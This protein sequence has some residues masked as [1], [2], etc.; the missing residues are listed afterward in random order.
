MK[1]AGPDRQARTFAQRGVLSFAAPQGE[2][3]A[4]KPETLPFQHASL[5]IDEENRR[6]SQPNAGQNRVIQALAHLPGS[7][8]AFVSVDI[9]RHGLDPSRLPILTPVI[10]SPP[11]NVVLEGNRRLAALKVL[12]NPELVSD[13]VKSKCSKPIRRLSRQCQG[14]PIEIV[15]SLSLRT[16]RKLGIGSIA[17]HGANEG[18]GVIPW[19]SDEAA[20]FRARS[21]TPEPHS[22]ALDFL[23]RRG[24]LTP[25]LR[26]RVPA[27]TF[28]R[29]IE[30]PEVRGKLGVE[31]QKGA[32]RLLADERQIAKPLM[33]AVNDLA[34][35]N[36]KIGNVYTKQQ[37]QKY[38]RDFPAHFAV[39]ATDK[40]R[41]RDRRLLCRIR[42]E[43][44]Y[45]AASPWLPS[46]FGRIFRLLEIGRDMQSASIALSAL[47]LPLAVVAGGWFAVIPPLNV[48]GGLA[49]LPAWRTMITAARAFRGR[50]LP[51]V[52]SGPRPRMST[53]KRIPAISWWT[54]IAALAENSRAAFMASLGLDTSRALWC[55][56]R[57]MGSR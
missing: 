2:S 56:G 1:L 38:A 48:A 15:T 44:H 37:R 47:L 29:L 27:T 50:G 41:R 13:A 14:D 43:C 40:N 7:K 4:R 30:T 19:G 6:V 21:G 25:E 34:S 52:R 39:T 10:G 49:A 32:L 9:V 46:G 42:R 24:D 55:D 26:R 20:R 51:S 28:K 17:T 23:Q 35:G 45:G 18:A 53:R 16:V 8:L 11:R 22:Q 5:I 57:G 33:Y 12:E 54:S 3:D 31:L 36:T